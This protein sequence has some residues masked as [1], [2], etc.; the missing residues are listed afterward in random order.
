[1]LMAVQKNPRSGD[2]ET[3]RRLSPGCVY[4]SPRLLRERSKNAFVPNAKGIFRG[5]LKRVEEGSASS[6]KI[7]AFARIRSDTN[8]RRRANAGDERNQ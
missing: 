5:V 8:R 4:P 2:V 7:S 6:V 1:M 3:R